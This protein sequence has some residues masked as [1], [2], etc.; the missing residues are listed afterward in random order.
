M[1]MLFTLTGAEFFY[2]NILPT[3]MEVINKDILCLIL[4]KKEFD[5]EDLGDDRD[6]AS[7][8]SPCSIL[9]RMIVSM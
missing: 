1:Q 7:Y 9:A 2:Y 3:Y 8:L 4:L 6:I 5:T